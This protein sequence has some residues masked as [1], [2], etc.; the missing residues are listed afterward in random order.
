M[1]RIARRPSPHNENHQDTKDTTVNPVISVFLGAL[2]VVNRTAEEFHGSDSS[3]SRDAQELKGLLPKSVLVPR[4]A[5]K[6]RQSVPKCE[7]Y[8]DSSSCR[9]SS[10][11]PSVL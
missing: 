2:G 3:V 10:T 9:L 6:E 8:V 7:G 4:A 5:L 11:V 1:K